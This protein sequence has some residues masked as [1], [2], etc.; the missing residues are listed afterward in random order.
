LAELSPTELSA[1][2]ETLSAA[3]SLS[4]SYGREPSVL[5][6]NGTAELS[7]PTFLL[8]TAVSRKFPDTALPLGALEP[9]A[10][11][12]PTRVA[13]TGTAL[14]FSR[15]NEFFVIPKPAETDAALTD[16]PKLIPDANVI[17]VLPQELGDEISRVIRS[18]GDCRVLTDFFTNGLR[19]RAE[20][21][22]ASVMINCGDTSSG[23]LRT[24]ETML[25]FLQSALAAAKSALSVKLGE[26]GRILWLTNGKINILI[27]VLG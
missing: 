19:L 1:T 20:Y 7:F 15:G 21:G 22:G 27:S 12:L 24:V 8:Q 16:I 6:K 17:C 13:V 10:D 23:Y 3:R 2:V 11:F 4:K 9:L 25:S 18:L 14:E 5:F 26:R